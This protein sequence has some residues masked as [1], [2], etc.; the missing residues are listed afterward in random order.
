[1][2]QA[3]RRVTPQVSGVSNINYDLIALLHN[4]LKG[5]AALEQYKADA[6]EASDQE[7]AQLLEQLERREVEDVQ[8]LKDMLSRRLP[9]QQRA[10]A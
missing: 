8:R 3:K 4:K 6:Q 10:A 2:E 7:V 1:M 5:V 9:G